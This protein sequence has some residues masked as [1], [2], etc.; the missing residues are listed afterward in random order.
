MA[1]QP[2]ELTASYYRCRRDE[3]F[4]DTFYDGFLSK[5][6]AIAQMFAK[7][8]FR[9]QKLMLRQSLLEMLCFDRGMSSTRE[10]IERLGRR[11]KEL[12]VTPEMY[13][14]WLDSLCEAIKKHDPHYTPDLEHLWRE[15]MHKSIKEMVAV[16]ASS[17]ADH[18]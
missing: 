10:E 12:R 14:M 8:D 15:A 1:E 6:P 9:I 16:G 17:A 11:H 2:N 5:S 3:R 4:L 7:T 13:A 18:H